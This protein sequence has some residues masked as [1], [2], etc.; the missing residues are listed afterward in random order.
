[1]AGPLFGGVGGF[2]VV[3]VVWNEGCGNTGKT[4]GLDWMG[5]DEDEGDRMHTSMSGRQA[6]YGQV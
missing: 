5:W 3:D 4:K 2:D 1:M 6:G